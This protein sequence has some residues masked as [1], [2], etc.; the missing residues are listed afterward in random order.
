MSLWWT[1]AVV[2]DLSTF[3]PDSNGDGSGSS[4]GPSRLTTVALGVGRSLAVADLS[5]TA[6]RQRVRHQRL[7]R[8]RPDVRHLADFDRLWRP[9]R[10]RHE[11]HHGSGGQPHLR[12]TP[13]VHGILLERGQPGSGTGTGGAP[14]MTAP[15]NNWGSSSPAVPGSTTTSRASTTCTCSPKAAGPQLGEPAGP[16]GCLR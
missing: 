3:L 7:P 12:R 10:T 8:H 2:P 6:G 5:I 13:V 15:P 9:A 11:T 4:P 1:N 16:A 14:M